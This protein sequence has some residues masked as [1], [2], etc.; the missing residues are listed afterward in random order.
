M[1]IK[2][3]RTKPLVMKNTC[4]TVIVVL[5]ITF[6]GCTKESSYVSQAPQPATAGGTLYGMYS[7]STARLSG[8][9][10]S[11]SISLDTA[12][13]MIQS[14]LTGVGYPAVD[15]AIRALSFDADTLRAYLANPKIA[16]VK[17]M[18]AQPTSYINAG[19]YGKRPALSPGAITLVIAGMDNDDHYVLNNRNGVYDN[20]IPCPAQCPGDA[21]SIIQQ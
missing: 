21:S 5:L 16:T 7:H 18:F 14:Y 9:N 1:G 8:P 11:Q 19:N 20:M 2:T 13:K 12:N 10:Y 15:T 3:P 4:T 17:F 6:L